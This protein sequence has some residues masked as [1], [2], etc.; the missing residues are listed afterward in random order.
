MTFVKELEKLFKPQNIVI[1]IGVIVV[2]IALCHYTDKKNV[3]QSG[4]SD[5][6]SV[7]SQPSSMNAAAVTQ[8]VRAA[9]SAGGTQKA[10]LPAPSIGPD[11]AAP[12]TGSTSGLPTPPPNC[13][14]QPTLNP[15][16]L[17]P[18][19]SSSGGSNAW[20]GFTG[21]TPVGSGGGAE[22]TANFL[23]SSYLAGINTVSGSLRNAN[24]QLRSEPPNPTNQV[25]PWLQTTIEPDLMRAPFEIGCACP[26]KTGL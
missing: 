9:Q 16:D 2:G 23:D 12:V 4:F 11:A 8:Q 10:P 7:I 20:S 21:Q 18:K 13:T 22:P 26:G 1:I 6:M 14:N 15:A 5:Q 25:S 24:L 19:T 17:L 3:T